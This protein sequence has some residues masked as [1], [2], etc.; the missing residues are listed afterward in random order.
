MRKIEELLNNEF[1][2]KKTIHELKTQ[3]EN[4]GGQQQHEKAM[5]AMQKTQ[6]G[7]QEQLNN[8]L[9]DNEKQVQRTKDLAEKVRQL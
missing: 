1:L 6:D 4:K 5:K 7:L 3:A 2:L 8:V 9:L